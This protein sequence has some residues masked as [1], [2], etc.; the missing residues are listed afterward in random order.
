[1]LSKL[2]PILFAV[3]LLAGCQPGTSANP[4]PTESAPENAA[5]S[6]PPSTAVPTNTPEPDARQILNQ[7]V[8]ALAQANTLKQE[9]VMLVTSPVITSTLQQTCQYERPSSAY[10][11]IESTLKTADRERPLTNEYE[12]LFLEEG[13]YIRQPTRPEWETMT[14]ETLAGQAVIN[15]QAGPFVLPAEMVAE[16][17]LVGETA[18][19]GTDV[20]EIE[21]KMNPTIITHLLG[22]AATEMLPGLDQA[23]IQGRFLVGKE[24]NLPY[25]QE[26]TANINL[27]G[28]PA[29]WEINI[30]STG[31]DE[32][33]TIPQP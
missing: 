19:N 20:Y 33:V 8:T 18:V 25:L 14:A 11:Q 22:E 27:Q 21:A 17:A 32:P 2:I 23:D 12:L 1:M 13:T 3:W 31:F 28:I 10:C 30:R 4:E 6:Q 26:F 24:T 16:A 7:S 29:E 9:Q 5:D 15:P